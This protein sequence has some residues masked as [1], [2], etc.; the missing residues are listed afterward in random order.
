[1][2]EAII[3]IISCDR[4]KKIVC[5]RTDEEHERFES[6][7]HDGIVFSFCPDCRISLPPSTPKSNY[8]I[9]QQVLDIIF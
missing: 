5:L 1:M 7:W 8:S 6:T 9:Q 4:C 2:I 3:T